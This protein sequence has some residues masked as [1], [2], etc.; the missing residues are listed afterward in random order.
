V[1]NK[2]GV[3]TAVVQPAHVEQWGER[4]GHGV[5]V[6][7]PERFIVGPE[8]AGVQRGLV[9]AD[10]HTIHGSERLEVAQPVPDPLHQGHPFLSCAVGSVYVS[11][12][13]TSI[14]RRIGDAEGRALRTTFRDH[15]IET[16]SLSP[17]GSG[18]TLRSF[19]RS[20]K[21]FVYAIP[22]DV[23]SRTETVSGLE[24]RVTSPG[25]GVLLIDVGVKSWD[26]EGNLL[27][28]GGLHAFL[29]DDA[30]EAAAARI[31]AAFDRLV[32]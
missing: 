7:C 4:A 14:A 17:D 24:A 8:H 5:E 6:R 15:Y 26:S 22:G 30:F 2:A 23:G 1:L 19:G 12:T 28:A 29:D 31:C 9:K 20:N 16:F 10:L 32:G 18:P 3:D 21:V 27:K 11:G 25:L 13:Y